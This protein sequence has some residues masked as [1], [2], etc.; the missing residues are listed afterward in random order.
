VP[1]GDVLKSNGSLSFHSD[2][3]MAPAKPMQLVWA[4]V[5]RATAE[6]PVAGP[7]HKVPLD[8]AL[9]AVTINAAY[10]IQLENRVGSIEVGKDANLSILEQ[11]PYVVAPEKLK[12]IRVRGTMLEGR[13]KPVNAKQAPRAAVKK[14]AAGG[15]QAAPLAVSSGDEAELAGATVASLTRLLAHRH[16]D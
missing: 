10:S 11:S 16:G 2:M 15:P 9:K 5:T 1:H 14:T 4:A 7:Q 3:P 6:G 12:D 8:D 13:V